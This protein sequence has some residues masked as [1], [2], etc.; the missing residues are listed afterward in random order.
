MQNSFYRQILS[1]ASA[2]A[3]RYQKI[4]ISDEFYAIR[5][6][7]LAINFAKFLATYLATLAKILIPEKPSFEDLRL[8][9]KELSIVFCKLTGNDPKIVIT[10]NKE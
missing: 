2:L 5:R 10:E 7:L 4:C 8:I 6:Y 9:L 1:T 3:E